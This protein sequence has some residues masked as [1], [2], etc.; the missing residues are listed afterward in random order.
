MNTRDIPVDPD[1][2]A[3]WQALGAQAP[4]IQ[5]AFPELDADDRE[6]LLSGVTPEEHDSL[7]P[8]EGEDECDDS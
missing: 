4:K 7:F 1:R 3:K 8:A 2:V 5:H 6:F